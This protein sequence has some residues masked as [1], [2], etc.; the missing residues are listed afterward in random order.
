[1]VDEHTINVFEVLHQNQTVVEL[2]RKFLDCALFC[3]ICG[4]WDLLSYASV[5]ARS[6]DCLESLATMSNF[7]EALQYK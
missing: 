3:G 6:E 4:C 2:N 7:G 5:P 1:M